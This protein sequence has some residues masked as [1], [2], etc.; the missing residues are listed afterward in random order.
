M[1]TQKTADK[2]TMQITCGLSVVRV[3][4]KSHNLILSSRRWRGFDSALF[5][6]RKLLS[7]GA[8]VYSWNKICLQ[9][10]HENE[11]I[12]T[13]TGDLSCKQ[14]F[15]L[16]IFSFVLSTPRGVCGSVHSSIQIIIR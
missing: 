13:E 8:N 16:T 6:I 2:F 1:S 10:T 9:T 15:S 7:A 3:F 12:K 4:G 11:E 14:E 5:N